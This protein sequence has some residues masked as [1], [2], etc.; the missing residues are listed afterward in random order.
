MFPEISSRLSG[1]FASP[2]PLSIFGESGVP[3][4]QKTAASFEAIT[5]DWYA[6]NGYEQIYAALGGGPLPGPA[7]GSTSRAR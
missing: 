1:L 2:P 7:N 5:T 4:E 6:R 3:G